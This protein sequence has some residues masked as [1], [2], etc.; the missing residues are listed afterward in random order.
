MAAATMSTLRIFCPLSASP[1][2]CQWLL[3]EGAGNVH[4][5][6]GVLAQL[7]PGAGRVE[8]VLAASQVLLTRTRLPPVGRRRSAALLAYAAEDRLA[9]DP[10]VNR[11][12]RL[13]R[14]DGED[15]LAVVSRQHLQAWRD[16]LAAAGV[17]VDAVYCATL[18]LPLHGGEWSLAW[19]GQ[20]GFVRTGEFEGGAT[21]CGDPRTPPLALQ[22]LLDAARTRAASPTALALFVTASSAQPDVEAWQQSLGINI[23]LVPQQDWHRAPAP[24]GI[25]FD[26]PRWHWRPSS[27]TLARWRPVGWALLA[28]LVLHSTALLADRLRLANEQ[29]QLGQQMEARF[30]TL[31]PTAVAVADP[32]LQTRRQLTQA[33]HAVDQPDAGD[34]LVMLGQVG[35]ALAGAPT[36]A[37]HALS[38][39]DGRMTLEFTAPDDALARQIQARLTQT[40][41]DVEVASGARRTARGALTLTLR[42]R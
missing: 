22:L 34:F 21:D 4:A 27:A 2:A 36:A 32:V 33:R 15:V 24:A 7:P 9:S 14:V 18:L 16:A 8:L 6:E 3:F 40:G 25:Q 12:S 28:T 35:T 13:G 10:D 41:L 31:F 26:S 38:Y 37:L 1:T 39:A 23:R 30:R 20:E 11:V 42:P 17:Q 19:N 5:G 29:Q